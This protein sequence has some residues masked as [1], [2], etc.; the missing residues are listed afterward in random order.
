[1]RAFTGLAQGRLT[2][3]QLAGEHL[4]NE[5]LLTKLCNE[6]WLTNLGNESGVMNLGQPAAADLACS[7]RLRAAAAMALTAGTVARTVPHRSMGRFCSGRGAAKEK[8]G[9]NRT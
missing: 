7:F 2:A 9:L 8:P 3:E 6:A 4:A 5:P 1:M